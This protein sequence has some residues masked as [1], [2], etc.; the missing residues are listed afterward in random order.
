MKRGLWGGEFCTDG[1]YV[2]TLGARASWQIV[3][4]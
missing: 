4:R 1:Y 2:A 3:E